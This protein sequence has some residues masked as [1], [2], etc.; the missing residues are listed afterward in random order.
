MAID[1][2]RFNTDPEYQYLLKQE[3]LYYAY[4]EELTPTQT[5]ILL[6]LVRDQIQRCQN[7]CQKNYEQAK[8]ELVQDTYQKKGKQ[9]S[10]KKDYQQKKLELFSYESPILSKIYKLYKNCVPE[11]NLSDI[12]YLNAQLDLFFKYRRYIQIYMRINYNRILMQERTADHTVY[13]EAKHFAALMFDVASSKQKNKVERVPIQV[14]RK[15][16]GIPE[17]KTSCLG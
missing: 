4:Q 14:K 16:Q 12:L 9:P 17:T 6:E 2:K 8:R 7:H 1:M 5:Q 11:K 3:L 10:W 15:Q 13:Q